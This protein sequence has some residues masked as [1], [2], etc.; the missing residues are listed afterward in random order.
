L[1]RH[2]R[3][4]TDPV[5][6]F[7]V[8]TERLDGF[9]EV[10]LPVVFATSVV[11]LAALLFLLARRLASPQLRYISL[12]GDYFAL[13]LLLGIGG[14]GFW[15]R[16]LTKTDVASVKELILGLTHFA[17][18][19]PA[20]IHPLFFGHLF[21]VCVLLA[22]FPVSKLMH[23]PGVFLSPTRNLAN[24]NRAVRHVNPWDYPVDV[25]TY[26]EYEDEFRDKMVGA[27]LPV[28]RE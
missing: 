13:F 2:L 22:Y 10:G 7:V 27:G 4:M 26:D 16:H 17:P 23:A 21:L 1:I 5:P 24:N 20:S 12:V 6:A 11:F 28:E 14:S 19:V 8:F 25:H 15:L 18:V 9:L 3:L